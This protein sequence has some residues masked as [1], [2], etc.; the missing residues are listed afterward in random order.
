MKYSRDFIVHEKTWVQSIHHGHIIVVSQSVKK[1]FFKVQ[2]TNRIDWKPF[3]G[4]DVNPFQY[5]VLWK[6]LKEANSQFILKI[7]TD[8]QIFPNRLVK[9]LQ[10]INPNHHLYA[11]SIKRTYTLHPN[12]LKLYTN[13]TFKKS[14]NHIQG[15][16]ELFTN[17]TFSSI[18]DCLQ[19]IILT[20]MHVRLLHSAEDV[21]IG[22]CVAWSGVESTNLPEELVFPWPKLYPDCKHSISTHKVKKN[23]QQIYDQCKDKTL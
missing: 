1:E 20:K 11:G 15:G 21:Y 14:H 4:R 19:S 5:A 3:R 9:Y 16:F 12:V 7:D 22:M 18:Y 17:I 23:Y 10:G 13:K 2:N 8:T 6:H